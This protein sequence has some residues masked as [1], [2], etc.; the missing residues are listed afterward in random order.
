MSREVRVS[1]IRRLLNLPASGRRIQREVDDEIRFHLE[2]RVAEL[3]AR[4]TP[5]SVARDNCDARVRRRHRARAELTRVRPAAA[6]ARATP[7]VG[8]R[9]SDRTSRTRR[10]RSA[11]SRGFAAI[12]VLV[13]ALGI[14]ANVTMFG[15]ID[16]PAAARAGA[17]HESRAPHVRELGQI[18][19][20]IDQCQNTLCR[21]RSIATCDRTHVAFEHVATVRAGPTWPFGRGRDARELHGMRVVRELLHDA[22]RCGR[23]RVALLPA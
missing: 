9:R 12:V 21:S 20:G 16:S 13:L 1:G 3:V 17:R 8:G 18:V 23:R 14:G 15:V 2:S 4:G 7:E 10:A 5:A 6:D 22:R 19:D 11:R